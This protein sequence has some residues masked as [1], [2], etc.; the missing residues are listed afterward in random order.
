MSRLKLISS[1]LLLVGAAAVFAQAS[2][3]GGTAESLIQEGD[4]L[5]NGGQYAEALGKFQLVLKETPGHRRAT[6]MIGVCQALLGKKSEARVIFKGM[7]AK[8]A[9]DPWALSNLAWLDLI[10]KSWKSSVAW[11][12]KAVKADPKSGQTYYNL[13]MAHAGLR[14]AKNAVANLKK[15]AKIDHG[16]L[17]LAVDNP[18]DF[19]P[20]A[21]DKVFRT[22]IIAS[23]QG[24][25]QDVTYDYAPCGMCYASGKVNCDW[26]YGSRQRSCITCN[27]SGRQYN[28]QSCY[29]CYG[30]GRQNCSGCFGS[31]KK[32]CGYC[33]GMGAILVRRR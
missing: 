7:L 2:S 3:E 12:N 19:A 17:Q 29:G 15:A 30:S 16:F 6:N 14:D 8:D 1:A 31:G 10:A 13:A 26:C 20:V 11:G 22:F 23:I 25:P 21:K 24:K 18:A 9:S 33:A 4:Q 32:S 28:G 27:G 5:Y